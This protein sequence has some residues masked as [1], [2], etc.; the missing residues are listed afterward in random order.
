LTLTI[1]DIPN[2]I[3]G[4]EY[5]RVGKETVYLKGNQLTKSKPLLLNQDYMK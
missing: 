3:H 1:C 2:L 4:N 5:G